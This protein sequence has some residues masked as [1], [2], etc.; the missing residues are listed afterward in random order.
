MFSFNTVGYLKTQCLTPTLNAST[1]QSMA[2]TQNIS[3]LFIRINCILFD[4]IF[5]LF[6]AGSERVLFF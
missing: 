4:R 3:L 1:I 6:F 2:S 5:R